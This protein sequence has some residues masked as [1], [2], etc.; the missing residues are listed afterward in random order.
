MTTSHALR[1]RA[2]VEPHL[3]GREEELESVV[4]LVASRELP[5]VVV[6]AGDAGIGKTS[7]WLA[8]VDEPTDARSQA[9]PHS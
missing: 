6:L 5:R 1:Q 4:E 7:L 2:A 9:K 3:V 8:A